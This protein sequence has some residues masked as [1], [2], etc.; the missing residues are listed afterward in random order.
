MEKNFKKS[1]TIHLKNTKRFEKKFFE[2]KELWCCK[3]LDKYLPNIIEEH[4]IVGVEYFVLAKLSTSDENNFIQG[5]HHF[6][7]SLQWWRDWFQR[8][9]KTDGM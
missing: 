3:C 9:S 7:S 5:I 4:Y 1:L 2:C 6:K 8:I